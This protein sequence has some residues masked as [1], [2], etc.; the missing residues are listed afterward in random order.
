[1]G[2]RGTGTVVGG[3]GTVTALSNE[4]GM[5]SGYAC[6]N[7]VLAPNGASTNKINSIDSGTQVTVNAAWAGAGTNTGVNVFWSNFTPGTRTTLIV[8]SSMA[9]ECNAYGFATLAAGA[10]L[11]VYDNGAVAAPNCRDL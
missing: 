5:A 8:D 10:M 11:V 7:D 9:K 1:T 3:G 6:M 2:G 4:T